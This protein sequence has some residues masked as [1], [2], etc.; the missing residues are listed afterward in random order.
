[1][2]S[3]YKTLLLK[4]LR[5]Q[6]TD[7]EARQVGVWLER[8][9]L[10]AYL[11]QLM[12]EQDIVGQHDTLPEQ[13]DLAV[14]MER[15]EKSIQARIAATAPP[16]IVSIPPAHFI[17]RQPWLRYAAV[18]AG[19]LMVASVVMWRFNDTIFP[20]A[21][22]VHIENTG[23]NVPV[24]YWLPDS[25]QVYLASG[26]SLDYPDD[27]SARSR[28]V[29][30][31]GDAFFDVARNEAKPFIIHTGSVSTR[32]LGTSFRVKTLTDRSVV[33]SVATGRVE[34]REHSNG[35]VHTLAQLVPGRKVTWDAGTR[36]AV[37]GHVDVYGLEQW[38]QGDLVF[39]EE[40]M[41][42]IAAEL[43]QR[44]NVT[45]R[46]DDKALE[47][48]RVSGSFAAGKPV[49]KIIHTLSIAGKF[50]YDTHADKK[51]FI[52]YK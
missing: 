36:Q 46:V 48:K 12:D 41:T 49:D 39:D 16:A 42:D 20:A 7:E 51:E 8:P 19:V 26:S 1:M 10:L 43:Q 6:C 25:S 40:T 32:V 22:R 24:V 27:F 44:Y 3:H 9:E 5:N 45:I 33:V 31:E 52:I 21:R 2:E 34:V 35:D 37:E 15:W 14:R 18:F 50:R 38:K 11:Y 17:T 4:F 28:D 29:S 23:A 13:A 47:T 30:L